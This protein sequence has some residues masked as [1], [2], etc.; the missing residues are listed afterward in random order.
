MH[1]I[2]GHY[3][4]KNGMKQYYPSQQDLANGFRKNLPKTNYRKSPDGGYY[5]KNIYNTLN[6]AQLPPHLP[7][8]KYTRDRFFKFKVNETEH[9]DMI[10]ELYRLVTN[11]MNR[12]SD[13]DRMSELVELLEANE[14]DGWLIIRA[15]MLI[16]SC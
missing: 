8:K 9:D 6:W 13:I 14:I 2:K 1:A 3:F 4:D 11:N 15:K 5:N 16:K 10:H 7:R 12:S